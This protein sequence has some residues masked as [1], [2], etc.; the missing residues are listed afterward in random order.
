MQNQ[1]KLEWPSKL[2]V[3]KA[4][5]DQLSRSKGLPSD[6][7]ESLQAAIQS[8]EG[9]HMNKAAL[10]KLNR[11]ASPLEKDAG[12]AKTPA[13]AQRLRALARIL[14]HPAA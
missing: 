11:A 7:I 1:Q 3:A 14:E 12:S 6:R 9:S 10:E 5:L 13:D 4:Y 8:A 2:I